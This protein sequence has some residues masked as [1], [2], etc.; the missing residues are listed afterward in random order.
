MSYVCNRKKFA[1]FDEASA[2]AGELFRSKGV[3]AAVEK[4]KPSKKELAARISRAIVGYQI[5]M[6]SIPKLYNELEAAVVDGKNDAELKALV[7]SF[8]GVA[9]A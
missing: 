9:E 5:P 6:L 2:Y 1:S 3:V 7:A 4:K 8:P